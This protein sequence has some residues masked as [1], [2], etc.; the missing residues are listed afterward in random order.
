MEWRGPSW[1]PL[2][3][4]PKVSRQSVSPEKIVDERRRANYNSPYV[5]LTKQGGLVPDGD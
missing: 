4:P 3:L 1:V 2:L 5:E